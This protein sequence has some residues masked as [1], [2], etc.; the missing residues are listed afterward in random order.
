MH[1][2]LGREGQSEGLVSI[3]IGVKGRD[4]YDAILERAR[5][6]G[7]W[8]GGSLDICGV[9]WFLTLSGQGEGASCTLVF[10]GSCFAGCLHRKCQWRIRV[11][12]Q[13]DL[14]ANHLSSAKL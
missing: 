14:P 8:K 2:I 5:N 12:L 13:A 3:K 10:Q 9:K 11:C 4:G 1:F 6:A 7:I